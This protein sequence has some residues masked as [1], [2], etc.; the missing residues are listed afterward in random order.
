[1]QV[2]RDELDLVT[3][4]TIQVVVCVVHDRLGSD[5]AFREVGRT[6]ALR[7]QE[8]DLDGG[9]SRLAVHEREGRRIAPMQIACCHSRHSC[10]RRFRTPT[11]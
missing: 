8:T 11:A 4:Q 1:M 10:R 6:A 2:A 3:G 5:P 7:V 9:T